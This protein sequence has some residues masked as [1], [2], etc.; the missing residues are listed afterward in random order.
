MPVYNITVDGSF[1]MMYLVLYAA[2]QS[3]IANL[4]LNLSP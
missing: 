1:Q 3:W 2:Y 4:S